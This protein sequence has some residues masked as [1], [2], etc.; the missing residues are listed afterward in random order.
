MRRIAEK[1]IAEVEIDRS[2]VTGS[3]KGRRENEVVPCGIVVT[4]SFK[5]FRKMIR[6]GGPVEFPGAV[7]GKNIII[8]FR[9]TGPFRE[10]ELCGPPRRGPGRKFPDGKDPGI[11]QQ[12]KKSHNANLGFRTVSFFSENTFRCSAGSA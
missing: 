10:I 1:R 2:S 7:Q 11:F 5:S 6:I 8:D 9:K 4:G 12:F 3:F